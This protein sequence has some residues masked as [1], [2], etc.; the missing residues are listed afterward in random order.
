[1]AQFNKSMYFDPN[2][3]NPPVAEFTQE[4]IENILTDA[5]YSFIRKEDS[6][7]HE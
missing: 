7:E 1:M 2:N 3:W 6:D 4:D 5:G